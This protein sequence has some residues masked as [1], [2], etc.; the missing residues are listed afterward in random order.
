MSLLS[1]IHE[2]AAE[3]DVSYEG[4]R[5]VVRFDARQA[6]VEQARARVEDLAVSPE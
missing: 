2:E 6:I 5:A 1:W 3:I 4:D